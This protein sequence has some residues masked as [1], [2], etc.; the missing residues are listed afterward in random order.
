MCNWVLLSLDISTL[1][2]RDL[3]PL[4]APQLLV[5]VAADVELRGVCSP[6]SLELWGV[7][8]WRFTLRTPNQKG[9]SA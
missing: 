8:P 3:R 7:P 6:W 2:N 4:I 1:V 5:H 9:G